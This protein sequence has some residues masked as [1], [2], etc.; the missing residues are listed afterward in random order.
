M[1][2]GTHIPLLLETV[3]IYIYA[4]LVLCQNLLKPFLSGPEGEKNSRAAN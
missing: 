4:M 3:N 2:T 1:L